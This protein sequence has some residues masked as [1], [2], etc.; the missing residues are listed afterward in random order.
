VLLKRTQAKRPAVLIKCLNFLKKKKAFVGTVVFILYTVVV[1]SMGYVLKRHDFY[2][3]FLKPILSKNIRTIESY[4]K[5]FTASPEKININIKHK[6]YLKLAYKRKEALRIGYLEYFPEDWVPATLTHKGK[7]YKIDI[8]LKGWGTEH[9]KDEVA[10]SFKV[11]VKGGNT[12]FGMKRFALQGAARRQYMNEWYGHKL[13]KY[14]GLIYL[15]YDFVDVSVNGINLPIYAIEENFEKRLI[16]NNRLREGPIFTAYL[17]PYL[18]TFVFKPPF[19][20]INIYQESKYSQNM[21]FMK[22]VNMAESRIEAYRQGNLPFSKVFDAT[23]MAKLLAFT[24]LLE[25]RHASGAKNLRFYFNPITN[26]IEP[27]PYDINIY[28]SRLRVLTPQFIGAG[29]RFADKEN[30]GESGVWPT[31]AFR[32]KKFFKKYIEFLEK[33][34]DKNFLD[35]FFLKTEK[36]G[37]EKERIV[38]KSYP[39]YEFNKQKEILYKKQ[40]L[41]R[42]Q[43]QP[44]KNLDI[45]FDNVSIDKGILSL[46]IANIHTFPVEVLGISLENTIVIKPIQKTVVQAFNKKSLFN[47][48]VIL[49]QPTM[50]S[51]AKS[52]F[53]EVRFLKNYFPLV[54]SK[55]TKA[56]KNYKA[57]NLTGMNYVIVNFRIP[58]G[59][60][61]SDDLIPRLRVVASVYGASFKAS[62]EIIPWARHESFLAQPPNSNEFSFLIIEESKKIIR[63][64]PGDWTIDHDIILPTGYRLV[65]EKGTHLKLTNNAKI[66]S[67]SAVDFMGSKEN[68]IIVSSEENPGQ[69]IVV[70]GAKK[71]SKIQYTNFVNLRNPSQSGWSVTGAVTFYE[72]PVTLSHVKFINNQSEDA[73]NIIRSKFT[74][75]DAFFEN[76][77]SDSLDIDFSQGTLRNIVFLN[78]GNDG[79]DASGSDIR[80]ENISF[81]GIR[82][83]GISAGEKSRVTIDILKGEN[84]RIAIASKDRSEVFVKNANV[85]NIDIG[86]TVF[87]KKTEFGPGSIEIES[88]EKTNLK[89]PY[90]VEQGSFLKIDNIPI[91]PHIKNVGKLLYG[92]G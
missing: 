58:E 81:N 20:A 69:G 86:F 55:K 33:F 53:K 32:E 56:N 66:I 27:I 41:I 39:Y 73:L 48:D 50:K 80:V 88:L 16:E 44:K 6:D 92:N 36:E 10:W 57:N 54:S 11:K 43:L 24:D 5:S 47:G 91:T 18:Q 49:L 70:M 38:H 14:I 82:D 63:I 35:Q 30:Q 1:L 77:F 15:R 65:A 31:I 83:K 2:G 17:K 8:R 68:P 25:T 12:I 28:Q 90:L 23:K 78:S 13:L 72:S 89:T 79:L 75:E 67:Y 7:T 87:Q 3:Q 85:K 42:Q 21:E 46:D 76:S 26:L 4:S 71:K 64:T 61:W 9:W 59:F 37:Q 34:S 40:D 84:S 19:K 29:Q 60:Q 74:I 62:N 51:M 22:L 52:V 45:Y